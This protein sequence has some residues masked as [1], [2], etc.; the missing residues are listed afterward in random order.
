ML[1]WIMDALKIIN[2]VLEKYILFWGLNCNYL[3]ISMV[4]SRHLV[5]CYCQR[6]NLTS[7]WNDISHITSERERERMYVCV[8][9]HNTYC[10]LEYRIS[11]YTVLSQDAIIKCHRKKG[12]NKF[13]SHCSRGWKSEVRVPAWSNSGES[14]LPGSHRGKW[15]KAS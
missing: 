2:T 3:M 8:Y 4:R 9:V 1:W 6:H 11:I 10:I 12:S 5:S 13:I 15:E 14:S 7:V